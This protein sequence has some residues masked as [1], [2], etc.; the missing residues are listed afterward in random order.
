MLTFITKGIGQGCTSRTLVAFMLALSFTLFGR[1][2]LPS[3]VAG[4]AKRVALVIANVRYPGT[5]SQVGTASRDAHLLTDELKRD[6]FEVALVED[7]SKAEMLR[8]FVDFVA[9]LGPGATA[10]IY[11]NGIGIQFGGQSFLMPIDSRI[12]SEEDVGREGTSIDAVLQIMNRWGADVK[13]IIVDAARTNAYE[14]RFRAFSAG[15]ADLNVTEGTLALY[16]ITPGKVSSDDTRNSGM[17]M[18]ELL[19]QL[20]TPGLS[21]EEILTRTRVG[22]SHA[23]EGKQ[24]PWVSSS[25]A[26]EFYFGKVPTSVVDGATRS[27]LLPGATQPRV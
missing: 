15:L 18:N 4:G 27:S 17:F 23:S 16:A 14:G 8:A 19:R 12:E 9:K 1:S 5:N 10:L 20:R 25:L 22:V 6:R 7:A 13:I 24:I 11:F 26:K 3:D 21:A 2:A